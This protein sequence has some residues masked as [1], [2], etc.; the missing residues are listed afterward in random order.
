[1]AGRPRDDTED[2]SMDI[3][4]LRDEKEVGPYAAEDVQSW[5]QQGHVSATELAW[6]EGYSEWQPLANLL[7]LEIPEAAL[8]PAVLAE[9]EP[10]RQPEPE[11]EPIPVGPPASP[12]QK[13]FLTYM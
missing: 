9:P 3:Y 7:G 13:A 2:R 12:R 4:L 11:P 10:Q 8:A 6:S 5:L 1:M